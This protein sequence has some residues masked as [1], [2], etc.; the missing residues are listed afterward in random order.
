MLGL[1]KSSYDEE[2]KMM[3]TQVEEMN[4]NLIISHHL[5]TDDEGR[6]RGILV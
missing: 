5:W 2:I 3:L 4:P 1:N 6:R